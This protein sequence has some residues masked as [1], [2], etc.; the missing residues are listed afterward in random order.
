MTPGE[1]FELYQNDPERWVE[2]AAPNLA[3]AIRDRYSDA[4]LAR[5]WPLLTRNMQ[6]AAWQHMDESQRD[7][8]RA[9]RRKRAA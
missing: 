3:V 6:Q 2:Y 5:T 8:V 1:E 4:E 9:I 7:R